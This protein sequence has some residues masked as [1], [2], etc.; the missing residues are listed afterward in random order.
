MP[1]QLIDRSGHLSS[2]DVR[3]QNAVERSHHGSGERLGPVPVNDNQV[4]GKLTNIVPQSLNR[5]GQGQVHACVQGIVV[6]D[7]PVE[8]AKARIA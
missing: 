2:L 5:I 3:D 1:Q 4:G 6:V 7:E 8:I